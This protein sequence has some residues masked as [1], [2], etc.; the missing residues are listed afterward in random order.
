MA[1]YIIIGLIIVGV[2]FAG[3]A[4]MSKMNVDLSSGPRAEGQLAIDQANAQQIQS[5]TSTSNAQADENLSHKTQVDN[6]TVQAEI[7]ATIVAKWVGYG[8]GSL[9]L[10]AILIIIAVNLF[11]FLDM[12]RTRFSIAPV[13]VRS[14][15]QVGW[16]L[17]LVP[18]V[19]YLTTDDAPGVVH[20]LTADG[21]PQLSEPKS[22]SAYAFARALGKST[23]SPDTRPA[24]L[25]A[26]EDVLAG[27]PRLN[28]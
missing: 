6:G 24:F 20:K 15:V 19:L 8:G 27:V 25:H 26:L 1:R 7:N 21:A 2:F 12:T 3:G 10:L 28:E 13:P 16:V 23:Q 22:A 9:V 17:P 4:A 11:S 18:G 5:Q 14:G